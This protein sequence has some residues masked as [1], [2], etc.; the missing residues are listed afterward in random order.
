MKRVLTITLLANLISAC[1]FYYPTDKL[2]N[3]STDIFATTYSDTVSI[4]E[5][6][7]V[8]IINKNTIKACGYSSL[9]TA[10]QEAYA[11]ALDM[12]STQD[13]KGTSNMSCQQGSMNS[14]CLHEYNLSSVMSD[15]KLV[16]T[17]KEKGCYKFTFKKM[18]SFKSVKSA[19]TYSSFA[20]PYSRDGE[21]LVRIYF[22]NANTDVRAKM[23]GQEIWI[24]KDKDFEIVGS[25]DVTFEIIDQRFEYKRFT[26]KV[27]KSPRII[28]KN[29]ALVQLKRKANKRIEIGA[30]FERQDYKSG[31]KATDPRRILLRNRH[32]IDPSNSKIVNVHSGVEFKL[33]YRYFDY[34]DNAGYQHSGTAIWLFDNFTYDPLKVNQN[35]TRG[36]SFNEVIMKVVVYGENLKKVS[37]FYIPYRIWLGG[38]EIEGRYSDYWD[39][40]SYLK[41][42]N[43]EIKWQKYDNNSPH[44]NGAQIIMSPNTDV[45]SK[46]EVTIH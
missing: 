21:S 7:T 6:G 16:N 27:P 31:D 46:I 32:S 2:G 13:I 43:G 30:G 42:V 41:P 28:T 3:P 33:E 8:S 4:E 15:K 29:V 1:T 44:I 10:R 14:G 19:E 26:I 36:I 23:N 18:N 5:N 37:T 22:V 40:V 20:R 45:I 11:L 17:V 12:N 24:R 38:G 25:Q 39:V 9:D 34:T 35:N